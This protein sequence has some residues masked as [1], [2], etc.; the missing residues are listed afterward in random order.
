[1]TKS[2]AAVIDGEVVTDDTPKSR[3]LTKA[4]RNIVAK[5]EPM[6][7]IAMAVQK[8]AGI[9]VIKELVT[10]QERLDATTARK[11]FDYALAQAKSE[12]PVIIKNRRVKYDAKRSDGKVD[13]AHEDLAQIAEQID[14][15]LSKFGLSYRFRNN[16]PSAG[17]LAVTC[18]ISHELGHSEENTLF[19]AVDT[20]AGKNHLQAIGSAA[21]YLS[22]YALKAALGLAAAETEDD[23]G[24]AGGIA[25]APPPVPSASESGP[26]TGPAT[27]VA[28]HPIPTAK[29]SFA[30]WGQKYIAAIKACDTV[31]EIEAWDKANT[32]ALDEMFAKAKPVYAEVDQAVAIQKANLTKPQQRTGDDP[33]STGRPSAGE[34]KSKG[35]SVAGAPSIETEYEDFL[36]WCSAQIQAQTDPEILETFFKAMVESNR[37]SGLFPSD[38]DKLLA[39]YQARDK[40]L[41]TQG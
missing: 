12:I 19:A 18:I 14:P 35:I 2:E 34:Q 30:S 13:Y 5:S 32:P 27:K 16:Q 20:G 6:N 29:E 21:T 3:A 31:E 4:D 26:T 25:K 40:A 37:D 8:G 28:P 23:D 41:T 33:I 39:Q 1:M 15:V 10:L 38:Y 36:K 11:A 9:D 24:R 17:Q 7:L 22:R